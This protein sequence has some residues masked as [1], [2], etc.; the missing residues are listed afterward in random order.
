MKSKSKAT[1]PVP[2][3]VAGILEGETTTT[4]ETAIPG[5]AI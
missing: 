5:T 2:P 1:T 3:L 4:P